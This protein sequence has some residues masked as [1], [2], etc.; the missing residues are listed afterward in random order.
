MKKR[1]VKVKICGMREPENLRFI[2]ALKPDFIGLIFYRKSPR[3]VLP[4]RA[5]ALPQFSKIRR[6]GVFVNENVETILEIAARTDLFAVQL[7]GD[8]SPETCREMKRTNKN[9]QIIK[10]FSVGSDFDG[11]QLED[12]EKDCDY[13]LFD[14][15]AKKRGGSGKVFDWEILQSFP[16]RRPFFLSGGIGAENV[17]SAIAACAGLPLFALDLN[18]RVEIS[19]ALKS[20]E[21]IEEII[22]N[23]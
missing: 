19:P 4:E 2:A 23:L 3:F 12:Y 5:A 13:F 17:G 21:I 20:P 10:A 11:K 9:L 15:K 22:K 7:H 16:V 6:V 18:S 8:E 1:M 14:T